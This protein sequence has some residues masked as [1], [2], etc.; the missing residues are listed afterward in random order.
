MQNEDYVKFLIQD[1]GNQIIALTQ[2]LANTKA[3]LKQANEENEK[4]KRGA[5]K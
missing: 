1:F 2:Q 5:K 3:Q 4:F